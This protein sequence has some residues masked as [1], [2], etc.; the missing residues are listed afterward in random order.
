MLAVGEN[1]D[2]Y[3]LKC[4]L[5]LAHVILFKVDEA[6]NRVK[7]KTC[8]AEHKYRGTGPAAKKAAA[9]RAPGVARTKKPAAA[10]AVVNDAPLQWDLKSRNMPPETSIRNY[11]IRE[12]FKVNNVIN[13]PVFGV[14]FVEKVVTDKSISVLFSDSVRLM[15][16]NV[17]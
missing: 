9:V 11:S 14:G 16:M 6:V 5:V 8:G 15:G 7:C 4:K 2:A 1:I 17:S 12:I 3:C 13:H 10:K